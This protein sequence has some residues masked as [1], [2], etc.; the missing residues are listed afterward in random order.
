[1]PKLENWST[2]KG[3]T[4]AY[5]APELIRYR[6]QGY[7]FNDEKNRFED[8]GLIITSILLELNLEESYAQTQ[9]TRYELG[10]IDEGFVKYLK[11][12]NIELKSFKV[13]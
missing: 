11:Y 6:L 13:S 3:T 7:V 10:T 4:N 1:M 2:T 12:N 8:N 9:N 5:I